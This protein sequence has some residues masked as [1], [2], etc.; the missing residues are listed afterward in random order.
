MDSYSFPIYIFGCIFLFYIRSL[1]LDFVYMFLFWTEWTCIW[2]HNH[3]LFFWTYCTK[4][5][6]HW[7]TECPCHPLFIILILQSSI[8]STLWH[9]VYEQSVLFVITTINVFH[10]QEQSLFHVNFI[11][12]LESMACM[13]NVIF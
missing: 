10:L 13:E 12:D 2:S 5:S 9:G 4:I 8:Q 6:L 7:Q 3:Y 1:V 11:I